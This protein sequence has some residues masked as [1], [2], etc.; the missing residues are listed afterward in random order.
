[1]RTIFKY[2]TYFPD[3]IVS[4]P[5]GFKVVFFG[6]QHDTLHTW[7]EVNP[8]TRL[9]KWKLRKVSITAFPEWNELITLGKGSI[10]LGG[11][12]ESHPTIKYYL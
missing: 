6:T 2:L 4:I 9:T 7:A 3:S 8:N 5:K 12:R 11:A 10:F 1:M